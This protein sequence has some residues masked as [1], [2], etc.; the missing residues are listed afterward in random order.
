MLNIGADFGFLKKRVTGTL[1]Y[2]QKQTED[3]IYSYA[4]STNRYRMAACLPT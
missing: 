4:V 3:L 2:Y 1:E